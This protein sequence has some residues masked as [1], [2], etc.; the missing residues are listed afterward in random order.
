M[1]L[2]QKEKQSNLKPETKISTKQLS[3]FERKETDEMSENSSGLFGQKMTIS[4]MK[5]FPIS[6]T[7]SQFFH[8]CWINTIRRKGASIF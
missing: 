3:N 5:I 8:V 7:K 4:F 2:K 6:V 1:H